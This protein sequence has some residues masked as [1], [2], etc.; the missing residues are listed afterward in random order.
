MLIQIGAAVGK[1]VY[2]DWMRVKVRF[3]EHF[4]YFLAERP[5]RIAFP[6]NVLNGRRVPHCYQS[7]SKK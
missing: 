4:D 7:V 2:Q 5:H 3:V 6:E 1:Q